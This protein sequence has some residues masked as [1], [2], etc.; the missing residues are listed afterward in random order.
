MLDPSIWGGQVAEVKLGRGGDTT[1]GQAQRRARRRLRL[2]A[3]PAS[4]EVEIYA[5]GPVCFSCRI[6]CPIGGMVGGMRAQWWERNH[7][8]APGHDHCLVVTVLLCLCVG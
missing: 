3:S 5:R 2:R 4:G 8:V 6:G 7:A 1:R